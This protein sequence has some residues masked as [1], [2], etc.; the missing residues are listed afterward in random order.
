MDLYKKVEQ[1]VQE[2]FIEANK[3]ET[4]HAARTVFWVKKLYPEAD[5]ALLIAAIAHD[6]ER[7][8]VNSK[9]GVQVLTCKNALKT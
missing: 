5:Q 9:F 2:S 4:K 3:I 7:A 6:I 1:F 8:L